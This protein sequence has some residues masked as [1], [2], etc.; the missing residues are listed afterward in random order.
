MRKPET[1][2]RLSVEKHLPRHLHREKMANPYRGGT[3]DSWYS[4]PKKDLWVEYKYL[5]TIPQRRS[6]IEVGLTAMQS[7]WLTMRRAEGRSVAVV[8][9][10]PGGGIVITDG[11]WETP[12]PIRSQLFDRKQIAAWIEGVTCSGHDVSWRPPV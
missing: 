2:Y 7:R 9:G 5:R 10:T 6:T 4:G 12:I 1:T 8:L 3:A 11:S